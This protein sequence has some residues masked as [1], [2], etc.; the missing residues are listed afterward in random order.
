MARG[1]RLAPVPRGVRPTPDRV[2]EAIFSHLG[3]AVV[4]ARVLDL[5]A[6]TG[7]LGVEA[8]SRGASLAVFVDRSE[9]ALRCVRANLERTG[10]GERARVVR[11]DAEVFLSKAARGGCPEVPFDLVFLDPPYGANP[12][13]LSGI[14]AKVRPIVKSGGILVLE[15]PR[16]GALEWP[17]GFWPV[18][19][20]RYGDTE[21]QVARMRTGD[22]AGDIEEVVALCPGT[23]DPVT[24]GHVD[25]IERA[26]RIFP[27]VIVGVLENPAKT[28][29]FSLEERAL[30]LREAL[31]GLERVE[32]ETFTGLLADFCRQRGIRVVVKGLR[33]V[34]DFEYE[35]Q[36][37]HMN[38]RLAGVDTFFLVASPEYSYLS[39]SI[40][41][42][43]A[44][45][46]GE[47]KG[48]VPPG[49]EERLRRKLGAGDGH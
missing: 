14:I 26:A 36:M 2:R 22:R 42:E 21:V 30:M 29:F 3:R 47:I 37:A 11:A 27:R 5:F 13:W 15:R 6:G 4:G 44:R 1:R 17:E 33:A 7:A 38:R 12:E 43:V 48:L 19:R 23:F 8:L 31:A 35:L 39:S 9:A 40:V 10:L 41:K 20:K 45:F 28:P 24:M 46:G 34:S 25:V 18:V 32:V 16:G 49:V